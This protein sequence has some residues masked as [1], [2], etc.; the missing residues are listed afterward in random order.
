[1]DDSIIRLL[2]LEC[3]RYKNAKNKKS[4][5]LQTIVSTF[6]LNQDISFPARSI[7][8]YNSV[9]DRK[10][11]V[12]LFQM[13]KANCEHDNDY[14]IFQKKVG[15]PFKALV[16]YIM[17]ITVRKE[18]NPKLFQTNG[19]DI[20][21]ISWLQREVVYL[22]YIKHLLLLD[23]LN[24]LNI[25]KIKCIVVLCDAL[26]VESTIVK[27]A[28]EKGIKTVTC[29]HGI[30]IPSSMIRT[31]DQLNYYCIPSRYA[32]V[33]GD[34]VQEIY[35]GNNKRIECYVCGNPQ[36]KKEHVSDDGNYVGVAC[37]IPRYHKQNQ[38]LIAIAEEYAKNQ[39]FSVRIR[40]HPMDVGENY[41]L[42]SSLTCYNKDIIDAK[43]ILAHTTT[44]IFSYMI[45]G[46][47]VLR[48]RSE[49]EYALLDDRFCF[50]DATEIERKLSS[51]KQ[52]DFYKAGQTQ[53][54]CTGK[55]S[56]EKYRIAFR[57]ILN[58]SD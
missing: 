53:I 29:Q 31:V 48:L 46:K 28:N 3:Y 21:D 57:Q 52:E 18:L 10:D 8:F 40:L 41:E 34:G 32:L 39:G 11:H 58:V 4:I 22:R 5:I 35:K 36:I 42:D 19:I 17:N 56:E 30:V 12:E 27:W 2:A 44:M 25:S 16:K 50:S 1:M 23:Q 47:K 20:K 55:E 7:L 33:W 24:K 43:I 38:R 49:K 26:F 6:F 14:I 37:D 15:N 54:N 9:I 45:M 13:I 51:L